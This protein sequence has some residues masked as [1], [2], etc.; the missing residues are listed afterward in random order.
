[1][2]RT[3][4]TAVLAVTLSPLAAP[5]QEYAIKL[6]K[7]GPGEQF[8][9][10]TDNATEIDFKL[11]DNADQVVMDKKEIKGHHF[12]YREVGLERGPAGGD[13]VKLTRT[14]KKAQRIVDGEKR[15]LPYQGETVLIEKKSG[16]FTFQVEGGEAVEGEDAKELNEDFNKGGAGKLIAAFLPAK[17]VKVDE[18]W[19]FDVG[20]LVKE[21]TK[22]GKIDIDAAKSTGSGKL[23]KAYQ[24]DGKQFGVVELT[25]SMPVTHLVNE[26]ER[27]PTKEGKLVLKVESDGRIDGGMDQS[28]LRV[29]IDGD[30]R[31]DI[32]A[33]GMDFKV[34]IAIRAKVEEQRTPLA[35]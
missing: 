22:D 26:G 5:A 18:P 20:M 25:I 19:K 34:D 15:T 11:L 32:T 8:Q 16:A 28:L 9:V 17:A 27:T 21:F 30:I 31:A 13:L 4:W 29:T 23:L 7:P 2:T 1:M 33:N 10:K 12:L 35:K 3:W 24:K 6:A 14:Y